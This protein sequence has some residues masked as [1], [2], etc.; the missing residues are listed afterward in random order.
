MF[1]PVFRSGHALCL[2]L[3]QHLAQGLSALFAQVG[4]GTAALAHGVAQQSSG[5]L[6]DGVGVAV[7]E[8]GTEACDGILSGLCFLDLAFHEQV[9]DRGQ[10]MGVN[11]GAASNAACAAGLQGLEDQGVVAG[12][13]LEAL[14]PDPGSDGCKPAGCPSHRWSPWHP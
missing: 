6:D 3:F 8:H 13:D 12:Q 2:V 10:D 14:G 9:V 5:L 7:L 1:P 11:V 4:E